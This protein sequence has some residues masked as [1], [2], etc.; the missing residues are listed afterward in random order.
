MKKALGLVLILACILSLPLTAAYLEIQIPARDGKSLAADLYFAL[1]IVRKPTILIQTP[2]NKN[3][4][5]NFSLPF[6]LDKYYIVIV[7]W[8]GF[9][10][11]AGAAVPGYDIGLDGYDCVEWIAAQSW[12]DGKV[13]TYGGSALGAVQYMTARRHPPHLVCANPTISDLKKDYGNFYDGGVYRK[14]RMDEHPE[15]W[16]IP[17]IL[18]HPSKDSYWVNYEAAGDYAAEINIPMFLATGW[19]DHFPAQILSDFK[20]LQTKSNIQVRAKHKLVVGP[21]SHLTMNQARQGDMSYPEAVGLLETMTAAFFGRFLRGET[22]AYESYPAIQFFQMGDNQWLNTTDWQGYGRREGVLFLRSFGMLGRS[23]E[24]N[25]APAGIFQYN[26]AS[27]VPSLD[28]TPV[29][30]AALVENRSDVL[31]YATPALSQPLKIQG[32]VKAVLCVFSDRLDTDF[33]VWLCDV[34]PDGRSIRMAQGIQ[35]LRYRS[36]LSQPEL[37][38]PGQMCSITVDLGELALTIPPGHR[39]R[40]DISSSCYPRNEKNLNDGGPMYPPVGSGLIATNSVYHSPIHL[41]RLIWEF[42]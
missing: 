11:S 25:M 8:R 38:T 7:D 9:Y 23:P 3:F 35:R 6:E 12:S 29:N 21:W 15:F 13:G 22:N 10:G 5:R 41:S 32:G 17:T 30:F 39:V 24:L 42:H 33:A 18:S 31:V 16:D 19:F 27:T 40:L 1:P 4:L 37:A 26:P 14:G 20:D 28:D 36:S 34:L 2:Y